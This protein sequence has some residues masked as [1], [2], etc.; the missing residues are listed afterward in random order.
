MV[1]VLGAAGAMVGSAGIV[2]SV[3][4]RQDGQ[5][6]RDEAGLTVGLSRS[7]T[8]SVGIEDGEALHDGSLV[9]ELSRRHRLA[10]VVALVAGIVVAVTT[11]WPV[12]ALGAAAAGAWV[13]TLFRMTAAGRRTELLEAIAT[14]TE[15][16]RDTLAAA[17]GLGQAITATAELAP[18]AIRTPVQTLSARLASGV[19]MED[20]LRALAIDLDDPS[21][22]LVVCAL[23]LAS[24]AQS[25]RLTDLLGSLADTCRDEVAMRLRVE[26]GRAAARSSVRTVALFSLGFAVVLFVVARTYLAPF[27]TGTGQLVLLLVGSCYAVGL[28]L[29]TRL[30]R[31]KPPRRLLGE[32]R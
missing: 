7:R 15:L 29:M 1:L 30:V 23:L 31:P 16:L 27:G 24:S 3:W 4:R 5:A 8:A 22:D 9:D 6:A 18:R 14:W 20:A 10:M 2:L 19:S 21:A 17:A 13:P 32:S 12:A 25:Q 28:W 11:R 26:A